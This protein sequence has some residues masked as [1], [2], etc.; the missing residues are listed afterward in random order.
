[1]APRLLLASCIAGIH[2][3]LRR[4]II[5]M[6]FSRHALRH[7]WLMPSVCNYIS[8]YKSRFQ[9]VLLFKS[10][11]WVFKNAALVRRFDCSWFS[12]PGYTI[13]WNPSVV[14]IDCLAVWDAITVSSKRWSI[15]QNSNLW[16]F[17][18]WHTKSFFV[19]ISGTY[20]YYSGSH[21]RL[22]ICG[23]CMLDFLLFFYWLGFPMQL[24]YIFH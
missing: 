13:R 20:G 8:S 24:F 5:S 18:T 2:S 23:S 16:R 12:L 7:I 14:T 15:P 4:Y 3:S 19:A 17:P 21:D 1:M 11:G 10:F 22:I 6:R 9:R